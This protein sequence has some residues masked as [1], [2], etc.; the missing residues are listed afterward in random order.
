MKNSRERDITRKRSGGSHTP[1]RMS[2]RDPRR[3]R[4]RIGKREKNNT[5]EEKTQSI[6]RKRT[7]RRARRNKKRPRT[8]G[9]RGSTLN[10]NLQHTNRTEQ[11][12][13]WKVTHKSTQRADLKGA[14]NGNGRR[15]W[16]SPKT[17]GDMRDRHHCPKKKPKKTLPEAPQ[18]AEQWPRKEERGPY[19]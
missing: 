18:R 7:R 9:K 2:A 17:P 3:N 14:R 10:I 15:F 12:F 5:A 13:I 11:Q 1:Y 6:F 16:F 8:R 4:R 19:E